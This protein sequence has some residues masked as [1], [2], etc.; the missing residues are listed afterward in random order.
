[1]AEIDIELIKRRSMTG[2]VA[3][4]TRTFLLQIISFTATFLLTIFLT[5]AIFGV[6]Y[7]V[8]AIISFLGYF[9]DIGLAAAL[10][11]KKA[12][13]SERDL[14]TTFTIQQILVLSVVIIALF[15]SQGIISFYKLD[16]SGLWLFR[17]LVV[18]FFL[19]SLKT[20]PSV[21]LERRLNFQALVIPQIFET[22]A[23]Y[24]VAVILA[25]RNLGIASFTWAVMARA[26]TGLIIIY[27][28]QPWRIRL[29]YIR[30]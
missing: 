3:L 23:F 27:L 12:E 18:A 29:G 5:P 11:Q 14:I 13:L 15:F 7:V 28:L 19:S 22:L 16:S 8:S 26:V 24:F 17:A 1:M 9:S 4:T 20:I 30:K 10:I 6:F 25:W 21:I 2:I